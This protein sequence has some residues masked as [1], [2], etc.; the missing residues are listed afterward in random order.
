[1]SDLTRGLRIMGW[2]LE[3][4]NALMAA[5]CYKAADTLDDIDDLHKPLQDSEWLVVRCTQCDVEWP[6]PTHQVLHPK[7]PL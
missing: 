7:E 2:S 5:D 3:G 6:C 1:M 4:G